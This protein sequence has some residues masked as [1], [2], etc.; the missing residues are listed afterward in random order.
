MQ[1]LEI[2]SRMTQTESFSIYI[3]KQIIAVH[4]SFSTELNQNHCDLVRACLKFSV[5]GVGALWLNCLA[6]GN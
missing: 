4:L 5:L 1:S 3:L 6:R 2:S